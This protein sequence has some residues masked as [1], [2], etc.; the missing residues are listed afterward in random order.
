MHESDLKILQLSVE[1][2]VRLLQFGQLKVVML[3]LYDEF[4]LVM[5]QLIL[6][7]L[8]HLVW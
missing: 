4:Q 3:E 5:M 7:R 2:L 8:L 6:H 1:F